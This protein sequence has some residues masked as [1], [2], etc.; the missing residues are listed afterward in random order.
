MKKI[1]AIGLIL[2]ILFSMSLSFA[3]SGASDQQYKGFEKRYK[4]VLKELDYKEKDI[5]LGKVFT[6]DNN[7]TYTEVLEDGSVLVVNEE[8]Y[9]H[10]TVKN[11]FIEIKSFHN[12][13]KDK[14]N[15]D[16]NKA[17]E[18]L[19]LR[20]LERNQ[21]ENDNDNMQIMPMYEE[22]TESHNSWIGYFEFYE[23]LASTRVMRLTAPTGL[24]A[25]TT[26]SHQNMTNLLEEQSYEETGDLF[27]WYLNNT[28]IIYDG[29]FVSDIFD[30]ANIY[31]PGFNS[32]DK[33][34]IVDI[35]MMYTEDGFK[36]SSPVIISAI[37]T[38]I[39]EKTGGGF[40]DNA[41]DFTT[42]GFALAT[43]PVVLS[44]YANMK[45][46]YDIFVTQ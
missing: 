27:L 1:I 42:A 36:K 45:N 41:A 26:Q 23:R 11:S 9:A 7:L 46:Q 32:V 20:R 30:N 12:G 10:S 31:F 13:K 34:E 24:F 5:E 21:T 38:A 22:Y 17:N 35:Y 8:G 4:D 2:V 14:T 33:E 43:Q 15:I 6:F 3:D 18:K 40:A 44:N 39:I 16:L 29:G 37:T 25:F 28:N 19:E